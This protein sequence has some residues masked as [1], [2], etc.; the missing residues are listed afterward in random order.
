VPGQPGQG[1]V[2]DVAPAGVED[3]GVAAVGEHVLV[4]DRVGISVEL[5]GT[6]DPNLAD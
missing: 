2:G 4:G 1:V 5:V 6:E 3:Q